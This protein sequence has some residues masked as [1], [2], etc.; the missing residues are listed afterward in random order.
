MLRVTPDGKEVWVQTSDAN[1]N[2]VLDAQT[3]TT[4]ATTP[5]GHQPVT[6]AFQPGVGRYGL[7]THL[8]D[9]IVAVLDRKTGHEVKRI[10]VGKPQ[11]N[12]TFTPDGA[13][14]FVSVMGGDEVAA[15]DMAE[16]AVVARIKTGAQ[17]MGLVLLDPARA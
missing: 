11:A 13:T 1:T 17:P 3:L 7:V 8:Q 10:D 6:L 4:I 14:A 9:S 16:L 12:T 2:V 15:I 5:V